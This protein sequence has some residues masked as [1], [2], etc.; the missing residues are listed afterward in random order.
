[1]GEHQRKGTILEKLYVY[2]E[3]Y[4]IITAANA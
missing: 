1:M 2:K 3:E 4:L